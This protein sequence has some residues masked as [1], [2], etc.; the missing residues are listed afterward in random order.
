MELLMDSSTR[1][2][3]IVGGGEIQALYLKGVQVYLPQAWHDDNIALPTAPYYAGRFGS[4][5]ER[6]VK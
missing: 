1:V 5:F 2:V 4:S 6:A 3:I